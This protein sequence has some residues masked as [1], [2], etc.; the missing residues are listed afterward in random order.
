MYPEARRTRSEIITMKKSST[1]HGSLRKDD[2]PLK[3]KPCATT[4]N[5]SSRVK[6]SVKQRLSFSS[7]SASCTSEGLPPAAAS[8]SRGESMARQI[9]EATMSTMMKP[10]HTELCAMRW[11]SRRMADCGRE[12]RQS[13]E[14]CYLPRD[15][16]H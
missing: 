14:G 5:A 10:S 9:D 12:Q 13:C 1:F 16:L 7:H 3:T 2:L 6:R 11:H 4:L 15:L 8:A